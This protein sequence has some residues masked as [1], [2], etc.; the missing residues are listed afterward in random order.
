MSYYLRDRSD[1]QVEILL[2]RTVQVGLFPNW[3]SAEAA[4]TFL[5]ADEGE[6]PLP[7]AAGFGQTK[8]DV[9]KA[10]TLDLNTISRFVIQ[11][12]QVYINEPPFDSC[13]VTTRVRKA[14]QRRRNLPAIVKDK[15]Q[16]PVQLKDLDT[17]ELT[18][19][20]SQQA[21][22]RIQQ[23]EKIH[24]VAKDFGLTMG[25]MRSKWALHKRYLQKHL[26]EGGQQ[27]CKFCARP[28][29][30]SIS[31]PDACARCNHG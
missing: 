24:D 28:F 25:Q 1:G 10:F 21:F 2:F 7:E 23:G 15:P 18:A 3:S 31:N 8:K 30:P 9:E 11:N 26:A 14:P 29:T 6:L 13:A 20:Q 27:S 12:G 17:V 19:D 16:M 22:A 4:R 5:K